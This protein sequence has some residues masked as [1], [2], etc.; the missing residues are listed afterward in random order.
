MSRHRKT[1]LAGFAE[2]KEAEKVK[3][4]YM[5]EKKR[6]LKQIVAAIDLLLDTMRDGDNM[7][8][9]PDVAEYLYQEKAKSSFIINHV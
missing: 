6:H 9:N 2:Q 7:D 3:K 8:P 5:H 4:E 1:H